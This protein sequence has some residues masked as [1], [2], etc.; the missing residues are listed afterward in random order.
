MQLSDTISTRSCCKGVGD[1]S[2]VGPSHIAYTQFAVN[3]HNLLNVFLMAPTERRKVLGRQNTGI[4][5]SN[6]VRITSWC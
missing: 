4:A 1:G 2:A 6:L 3:V 5:G